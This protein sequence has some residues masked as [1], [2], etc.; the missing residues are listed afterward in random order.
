MIIQSNIIQWE[1]SSTVED[2]DV[3]DDSDNSTGA[4][5]LQKGLSA[6]FVLEGK[7]LK[8]LRDKVKNREL[9]KLK[10]TGDSPSNFSVSFVILTCM[11]S[12]NLIHRLSIR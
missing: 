12:I 3:G 2:G 7:E 4:L 1:K 8:A 9:H 11:T 10:I 6:A 5:K